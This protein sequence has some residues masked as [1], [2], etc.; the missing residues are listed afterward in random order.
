MQE[1]TGAIDPIQERNNVAFVAI[2]PRCKD[3]TRV[4]YSE[5]MECCGVKYPR[6]AVFEHVPKSLWLRYVNGDPESAAQVADL[7]REKI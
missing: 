4:S 6:P 2:C 3:K 1:I 5:H 7:I